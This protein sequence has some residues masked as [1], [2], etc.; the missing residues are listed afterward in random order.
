M[1]AKARKRRAEQEQEAEESNDDEENSTLG[2]DVLP[3]PS[4]GKIYVDKGKA[5]FV[6]RCLQ[7]GTLPKD[8]LVPLWKNTTYMYTLVTTPGYT[9]LWTLVH[10]T[11]WLYKDVTTRLC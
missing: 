9:W 1:L 5:Q 7:Q 8:S 4:E 2:D 10:D 11:S 3:D 6:K